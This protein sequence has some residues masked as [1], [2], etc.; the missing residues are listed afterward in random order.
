MN[1]ANNQY[2]SATTTTSSS[3]DHDANPAAPVQPRV[4]ELFPKFPL[5]IRLLIWKAICSEP[6]LLDIWYSEVGL[7]R[8]T[9]AFRRVEQ[10]HYYYTHVNIPSVLHVSREARNVGLQHYQL[11]FGS[12][13]QTG[14]AIAHGNPLD[15]ENDFDN[16]LLEDHGF[17][18]EFTG[19]FSCLQRFA[20]NV[21]WIEHFGLASFGLAFEWLLNLLSH[22][23]GMPSR[24][25]EDIIIYCSPH[26]IISSLWAKEVPL[27]ADD[28]SLELVSLDGTDEDHPQLHRPAKLYPLREAQ[29]SLLQAIKHVAYLRAEQHR[30]FEPPTVSIAFMNVT[31]LKS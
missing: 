7:D 20:L 3:P 5:E 19:R 4:F 31:H 11:E 15:P 8:W 10:P 18:Q 1:H 12:E 28:V 6:R 16:I 26:P 21:D 2:N 27:Q 30:E 29:N 23:E 22:T 24:P 17:I 13:V 25:L 14:V 9:K